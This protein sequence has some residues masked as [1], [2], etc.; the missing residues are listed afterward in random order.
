MVRDKNLQPK[1]VHMCVLRSQV[2]LKLLDSA[3]DNIS[4]EENSRHLVW[5]QSL[6][7][8]GRNITHPIY[9]GRK[10]ANYG[11]LYYIF[12]LAGLTVSEC[13]HPGVVK[14]IHTISVPLNRAT[15]VLWLLLHESSTFA[16]VLFTS[17]KTILSLRGIVALTLIVS[18]GVALG[19]SQ[20]VTQ[21]TG[22]S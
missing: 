11:S 19:A 3:T 12:C 6:H 14:H 22:H 17:R 18:F 1:M 8:Q 21:K 5:C 10:S 4:K 16:T 9:F 13:P 2:L 20:S 15:L 7:T